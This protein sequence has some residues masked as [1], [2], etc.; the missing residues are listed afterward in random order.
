M[1]PNVAAMPVSF[2]AL[3]A[4]G[5]V[6][7]MINFTAGAPAIES[8]CATAQ[9]DTIITSQAFVE[10]FGLHDL[11]ANLAPNVR[12]I[13]LEEVRQKIGVAQ[14]IAGLLTP[15][16]RLP[17]YHVNPHDEA[18]VLFTSGSEGVPK[19]VVLSHHNVVSNIEQISAMLTLL[20]GEQ[21][22][23]ALPT[24]HC[25][26]LTAGMLWPILKGAKVFLYPSP[27]HYAVVP[28]MSYQ[29]NAKLIFG[30]D[31]FFTGYARKADPYDFYSLRAMVSG[32]ERLRPETRELFASRFHQAIFEGY[33]VTETTPVLSV[34]IPT[35]FKHGSVGQF[36]PG[37]DYRLE[38]VAGIKEGG[39]LWVKGPNVMLGYLLSPQPGLLQPPVDGWHDTGDI[40]H[41]DDDGY[42]W[43]K[44][45]AKR[46]AKIG[47][48]MVSLTAVESYINQA[49]PEGHHVVVAVPDER[50][51][52]QLVLV[53]DDISL[54]RQTVLEA[55]KD[56]KVSELMVP[57]KVI[58]VETVP[59]LG[60]GKTNY[61]AVQKIAEQHFT[62][63]S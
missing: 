4:Y 37:I 21:L 42:V 25:F 6:P 32:A 52:E 45:R 43:I 60:S 20:P 3:Q 31:T 55:A 17:G 53:T 48:E 22:L 50:K 27:V 8:A 57:K 16:K 24:F 15:V 62:A 18:V 1:L 34:N 5:Y 44:G 9:L 19:G 26:G 28:E 11:V 58:L 35:A 30:T 49:S 36:V 33:G 61:P 12:F 39:Q 2:F 40:V 47:G 7:A 23:N 13:Y 38:P 51:G 10:A 29:T 56:K 54:S 41:V 46:F 14:K 63:G 59:L